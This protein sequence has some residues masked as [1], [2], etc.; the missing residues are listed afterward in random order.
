MKKLLCFLFMLSL[1]VSLM[2]CSSRG[3]EI[4]DPVTFYYPRR[5]INYESEDGVIVPRVISRQDLDQKALLNLFLLSRADEISRNPFPVGTQI[6]RIETAGKSSVVTLSDSLSD[7]K[8]IDLTIACACF[9]LTAAEIL[10]VETVTVQTPNEEIKVTMSA[11]QLLLNHPR[12]TP[13]E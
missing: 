13:Q 3:E 12:E 6:E 2:A 8:G 10:D 1:S 7:L 11:S 9:T 4:T 5:Q